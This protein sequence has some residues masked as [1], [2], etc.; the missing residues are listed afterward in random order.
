MILKFSPCVSNLCSWTAVFFFSPES[1]P[2]MTR[3]W[4]P[5]QLLH[6]SFSP[7]CSSWLSLTTGWDSGY[8]TSLPYDAEFGHRCC[9]WCPIHWLEP[10]SVLMSFQTQGFPIILN[11]L[12]WT[13]GHPRWRQL[14]LSQAYPVLP[15]H[16]SLVDL[17]QRH[18]PS[19][20]G[21]CVHAGW[22]PWILKGYGPE[23]APLSPED[24]EF[25]VLYPSLL[26]I[27]H[28]DDLLLWPWS[29]NLILILALHLFKMVFWKRGLEF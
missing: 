2:C 12:I 26:S 18:Y 10:P 20:S 11:I 22:N 27:S 13:T 15:T 28:I 25:L 29:R 4:Q 17:Q 6:F 5:S 9:P 1:G 3:L 14:P 7:W 8:S 23:T 16:A 24:F 21:R 19:M